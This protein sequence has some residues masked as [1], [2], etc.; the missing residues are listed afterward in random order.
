MEELQVK[1]TATFLELYTDISITSKI[2]KKKCLLPL[3][4]SSLQT[5]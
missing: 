1:S 2:L 4:I 3:T 5:A